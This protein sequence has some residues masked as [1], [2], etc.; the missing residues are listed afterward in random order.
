M[1]DNRENLIVIAAGYTE[2]MKKFINSNPGLRSRFNKY[3]DFPDYKPDELTEIFR[4][5]CKSN[6]YDMSSE[7]ETAIKERFTEMYEN[8]DETFGNGRD[9][10]NIFEKSVI[11]QASRLSGIKSP[12]NTQIIT[13]EASD[14]Q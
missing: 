11:K 14:V 7:A 10:R 6:G 2:P 4:R 13:L 3:L 8:R 5:M 1:E 9:V 12:T